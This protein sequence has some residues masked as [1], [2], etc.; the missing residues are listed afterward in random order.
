MFVDTYKAVIIRNLSHQ[1]PQ[2]NNHSNHNNNLNQYESPLRRH[3]ISRKIQTSSQKRPKRKELV[4]Q[5]MS[6]SR[7]IDMYLSQDKG[8]VEEEQLR[9]L[10]KRSKKRG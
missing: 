10:S 3:F 4:N 5:S 9:P 6:R 7:N 8:R 2:S 1:R